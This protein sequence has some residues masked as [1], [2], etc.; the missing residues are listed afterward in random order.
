MSS[1]NAEQLLEDLKNWNTILKKYQVPNTKKALIQLTNSFSFYLALLALQFYLFDKTV[2]GSIAIAIL[3]GFILG[4]IFIIQH[5]C[6][7]RSF[8][9]YQTLNDI[10]GTVCSICTFIP[11]KYWAKSH[12]FH[13]AHNGQLEFSDIGDVECLTTEEYAALPLKRKD[14]LPH[15][16]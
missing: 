4:R 6:G 11:Y 8:T 7:H 10:I 14:L 9:R 12:N 2:I 5:D 15:L 3:N 1:F 16:P 13:H